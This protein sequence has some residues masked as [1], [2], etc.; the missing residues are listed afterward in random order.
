MRDL[1]NIFSAISNLNTHEDPILEKEILKEAISKSFSSHKIG[2]FTFTDAVEMQK[3]V[4]CHLKRLK[5]YWN[6]LQ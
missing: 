2:N 6:W 5:K 4:S 3:I 1:S